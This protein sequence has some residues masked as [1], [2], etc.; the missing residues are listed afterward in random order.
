MG[1]EPAACI[2][3]WMEVGPWPIAHGFTVH[4][5]GP[6]SLRRSDLKL[7]ELSHI[8]E[9]LAALGVW[10]AFG[11]SVYPYLSNIR[12]YY[13]H[14]QRTQRQK[15]E[16]RY[17]KSVRIAIEWS[18]GATANLFA[19]LRNLSKLKLLRSN[20]LLRIYFVCVLLRNCHVALYGGQESN[21]FDIVLPHD[22]LER[23]LNQL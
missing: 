23:Y 13:K 16:N 14:Q 17:F 10:F 20:R 15:M 6:T 12:T 21:C 5:F 19:Y 18:Y 7:L 4:L 11:D 22:M 3:Q 2:P 1:P 8:N 9:K